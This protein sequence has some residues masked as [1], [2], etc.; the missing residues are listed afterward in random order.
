MHPCPISRPR[1]AGESAGAHRILAAA[2]LAAW[3]LFRSSASATDGGGVPAP[4]FREFN[5]QC[6]LVLEDRASRPWS[7]EGVGESELAAREQAVRNT[8]DSAAVPPAD[9]ALCRR[10]AAIGKWRVYI[11]KGPMPGRPTRAIYQ[12]RV[13]VT[14]FRPRSRIQA[15]ARAWERTFPGAVEP[16]RDPYRRACYRALANACALVNSRPVPLLP[17]AIVQADGQAC[18]GTT[19]H[20]VERLPQVTTPVPESTEFVTGSG[21]RERDLP[22]PPGRGL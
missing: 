7:G 19:W 16:D 8:C 22:P 5:L 3:L 15:V 11:R 1:G 13:R 18:Q 9:R 4:V 20:V 12:H 14:A 2:G 6:T 10:Q 17:V 21:G